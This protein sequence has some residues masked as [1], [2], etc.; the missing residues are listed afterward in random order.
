MKVKLLLLTSALIVSATVNAQ[1]L[2]GNWERP[3]PTEFTDWAPETSFYLYNVD[4]G[5]FYIAY[6]GGGPDEAPFWRTRASVNDTIGA[7]VKFTRTNPDPTFEDF[8]D[9]AEDNTYLLVSWVPKFSQFM[10]TFSEGAFNSV[11]TDNNTQHDHGWNILLDSDGSFRIEGNNGL[12]V[13]D[14]DYTGKY[15]GVLASDPDRVLYLKDTEAIGSDAVF[16]E[17]WKV[18]TPDAYTAYMETAK[19]QLQRVTQANELR[20]AIEEALATYPSLDLSKQI[21]VYNNTSSSLEAL[22]EATAAVNKAVIDEKT[23]E[24]SPTNPTDLTDMIK[25]PTFDGRNYDGWKGDVFGAGGDVDD[26]AEHFNKNYDTYQ[27]IS[28]LPAGVYLVR[29]NGFYR[30]GSSPTDDYNAV[31]TGQAS[32]AKLYISG[33]TLGEFNTPIKHLT[34][35]GLDTPLGLA[36]GGMETE[37]E[38]VTND[39]SLWLPNTMVGANAYFHLPDNPTLY[40]SEIAGAIGEGDVL[41][42]GV[43]KSTLINADWSIFDDFQL[44]YYGNTE[45]AYKVIVNSMLE[46]NAVVLEGDGVFYGQPEYEAYESVRAALEA[47]TTL[48]AIQENL[49]K[50]TEAREA[51]A[52]SVAAYSQ[53][54]TAVNEILDWLVKADQLAGEDLDKLADYLQEDAN[55]E[56]YPRG[57]LHFIIPTYDENYGAGVLSAEDILSEIEY[58][59]GLRDNAIRNSMYDGLDLTEL[60]KNAQFELGGASGWLTDP[61]YNGGNITNWHG[62]SAPNFSA[63]CFNHN[64]DVYQVIEGLENGLYEVSVQA[65]YRTTDNVNAENAYNYGYDEAKVLSE[66]YL[67][68]FST[69]VKNVFEI[70]FTENLANNCYATSDGY[71]TLDG[72]ASASAAFSLNDESQNFTQKVYGLVTDGKLRL[73]IRNTTG[74]LNA[75]WTLFDNFKLI[76]RAKNDEALTSVIENYTERAD[77]LS[78][79]TYGNPE[80]SAL[81]NAI[82]AAQSA[83]T[84]NAK[85]DALIALVNAYNTA[86]ASVDAYAK[87]DEALSLFN[88]ALNDAAINNPDSPAYNEAA[89]YYDEVDEAYGN[90]ELS[91]ADALAAV[92]EIS[93]WI[94]RLRIPDYSEASPENPV[95]MTAAIV[96]PT[97]DIVNDF[98]GWTG[99]AFGT[100]G[101]AGANAEHYEKNFDSYQIIYGLPAG[102]YE[103][104]VKGMYRHGSPSNDFSLFRAAQAAQ[105]EDPNYQ[106]PTLLAFLYASTASASAQKAVNH[107]CDGGKTTPDFSGTNAG[108]TADPCYVADSRTSA[109]LYFHDEAAPDA[110][111]TTVKIT[112]KEGEELRIGVKKDG[113]IPSQMWAIFDDFKLTYYGPASNIPGDVN[114]D[115]SVNINDVVAIIN[116]MAGTANWPNANVNSDPE[117]NV[118]INDVVAVINIMAGK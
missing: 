64:F 39:G 81:Q 118:D 68:E 110:Y 56:D 75:R 30:A 17:R 117:G 77:E 19:P 23:K 6:Q 42:F 66:V 32:N 5:G 18:M 99:T 24:V 57:N 72:M 103:L 73:G 101:D 111:L 13:S 10:C 67:N 62:G 31:R 53:Y 76:F 59:Q 113:D 102:V 95:D 9:E 80:Q 20:T 44:L 48:E 2:T 51:L 22:V 12:K 115:G 74:T 70:K 52:N 4:G 82:I 86:N 79:K 116:Q 87:L 100:G 83:T 85:Y 78:D 43:K 14:Y 40:R 104:S 65:F 88:E 108:N 98:T 16:Y 34:E 71:Y 1:S 93:A 84:A 8:W 54:I 37:V 109:D 47:S 46:T 36:P 112:I 49:P 91:A 58:I 15:I 92:N 41:R 89:D 3:V 35:T 28:G 50:L 106:D 55:E 97:F 45:E 21:A 105:A 29:V 27:E 33:A 63:E 107:T 61:Q 7:E 94:S 69:P 11:W 96:N 114:E 25:N 38:L 90:Q 26:L 60:I